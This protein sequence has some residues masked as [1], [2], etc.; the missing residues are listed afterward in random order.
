MLDATVRV[1]DIGD[2]DLRCC[3]LILAQLTPP[4]PTTVMPTLEFWDGDSDTDE[5]DDDWDTFNTNINVLMDVS[6]EV[7]YNSLR[8]NHSYIEEVETLPYTLDMPT[9]LLQIQPTQTETTPFTLLH[10]C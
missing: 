5:D 8:E 6:D 9:I 3:H 1:T 10:N 4:A 2:A 7:Y